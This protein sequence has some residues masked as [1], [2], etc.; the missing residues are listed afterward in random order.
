MSDI[1]QIDTFFVVISK[2]F[3]CLWLIQLFMAN[4][5]HEEQLIDG[6]GLYTCKEMLE[7]Q[8]SSWYDRYRDV[9][10]KSKIIRPLS[11]EFRKYLLSDGVYLPIGS[12]DWWACDHEYNYLIIDVEFS[13]G[14]SQF[15]DN[16]DQ[17]SISDDSSGSEPR[18][19]YSFPELDKQI[20]DVV[21]EY[22]AVFPKLNFTSPRVSLV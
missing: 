10:L 17:E 3:V 4:N 6:N 9:A 22:G 20:R 13:E 14:T 19:V 18:P 21:K 7:F 2:L 16:D 12:E 11:E 15:S 1:G 5:D 8:Y